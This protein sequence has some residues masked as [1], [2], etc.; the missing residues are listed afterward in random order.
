MRLSCLCLTE[1]VP[2][3]SLNLIPKLSGIKTFTNSSVK[4]MK[5]IEAVSISFVPL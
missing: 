4:D 2:H 3:P 1:C 5:E